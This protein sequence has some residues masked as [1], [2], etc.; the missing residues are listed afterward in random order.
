MRAFFA[1]ARRAVL[2]VLTLFA[3]YANSVETTYPTKPVRLVVPFPAGGTTDTIGR[4]I[5]QQ[6]S[7]R[8]GQQF[9]I[10]NRPGAAGGIGADIVAKASADGYTI[11]LGTVATHSIN[12]SLYARLPYDAVRDFAPISLLATSPNVLVVNPMLPARSVQELVALAKAK[13][14]A[15]T[16]ASGG[17]GTT[18]H[19][20]G[21]LFKGMAGVD[22]THVPYKG[23]APAITDVIGGQVNVMFDNIGNSLP[24]I[25]AGKLRALAVTGPVRSPVLPNAPTLAELGFGGYNITPWFGLFAPAGTP[26]T[27]ITRLNAA[28]NAAL[29]DK[30]VRDLLRSEGIEA[31]GNSLEQFRAFLQAESVRWSKLVKES[32]AH[33]D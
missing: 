8:L 22:M 33:I 3:G 9:V 23:N 20:A 1:V 16:F 17:N 18:H 32:G 19:L 4:L 26:Q 25:K 11:L 5:G 28:V 24:H 2:L 6:L 21:E 13:P 10:D 12:P 30:Q 29:H 14:G 31:Q 7:A 27:I 15:L